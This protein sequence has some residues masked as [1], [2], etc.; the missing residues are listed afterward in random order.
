LR[1]A[2]AASN[3]HSAEEITPLL[4][5]SEIL[6]AQL[7]PE[8]LDLFKRTEPDEWMQL[9]GLDPA[10]AIRPEVE[11][12][13][14]KFIASEGRGARPWEQVFRLLR[15][16]AVQLVGTEMVEDK[17]HPGKA[18]YDDSDAVTGD[19]CK[20][21]G[22]KAEAAGLLGPISKEATHP[23][24]KDAETGETC[25]PPAPDDIKSGCDYTLPAK[26][27]SRSAPVAPDYAPKQLGGDKQPE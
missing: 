15:F 11:A 3:L 25:S 9:F 17:K 12:A 22:K 20:E 14:R 1:D 23:T 6:P 21:Y 26:L 4:T 2:I 18:A 24:S 27:Q 7:T 8:F 13:V 19:D 16:G 5:G 10:D